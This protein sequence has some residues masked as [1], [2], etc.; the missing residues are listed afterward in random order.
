MQLIN[1]NS[2][3]YNSDNKAYFMDSSN[4]LRRTQFQLSA[5][6]YFQLQT[7]RAGSFLIGPGIKY[8]LSGFLKNNDYDKLHYMHLDLRATWLFNK[9]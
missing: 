4:L 5:G 8:S 6:L 3:L 1:K 9:K 2:L 7:K